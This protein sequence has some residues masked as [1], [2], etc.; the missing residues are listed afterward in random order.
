[1]PYLTSY[2]SAVNSGS[3]ICATPGSVTGSVTT[4]PSARSL[5]TAMSSTA[6]VAAP[7]GTD[8]A[9]GGQGAQER[10]GVGHGGRHRARRVLDRRDGHDAAPADQPVGGLEADD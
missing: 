5:A 2:R 9:G 8:G 10:R 4:A 3:G 1:M 6:P 7:A